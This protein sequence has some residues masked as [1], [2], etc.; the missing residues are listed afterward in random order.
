M[1]I[2]I[3]S[4]DIF[5]TLV[6]VNLRIPQIWQGILGNAYTPEEGRRG[7]EAILACYP[8][9][10]HKALSSDHFL[11]MREVYMDC[12]RNAEKL[13]THSVQAET[14]VEHLLL[15][16]GKAPLYQDVKACMESVHENYGIILS[17]DSNHC[18]VDEL[19]P[20]FVYDK[21]FI[22]D[23]LRCY[24]AGPD[25]DFFRKVLERMGVRAEEIL[26]IGDSSSDVLGAHR[27]GMVSCWLN[28]NKEVWR[29]KIK[30]DYEIR[31]LSDLNRILKLQGNSI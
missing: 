26:H 22:S 7:A 4:F 2:K 11:T 17:S 16:H 23:D 6:D 15:Q 19:L 30:P 14:I 3:V 5:Q 29:Q 1:K 9:S 18:M 13:L 20:Y 8:D 28:R 21:S 25:G 12:A 10:L 24:K 31:S 27:A